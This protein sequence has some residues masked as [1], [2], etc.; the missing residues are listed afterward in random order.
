MALVAQ[1]ADLAASPGVLEQALNL[2]ET[3]SSLMTQIRYMLLKSQ[4]Y[5]WGTSEEDARE[6]TQNCLAR[7]WAKRLEFDSDKG[8]PG[9]WLHGFAIRIVKEHLQK[10]N[11]LPKQLPEDRELLENIESPSDKIS[12]IENRRGIIESLLPEFNNADQQLL[13]LF[14][15]EQRSQ[16]ELVEILSI[17]AG[18]LRTRLTRVRSKLRALCQASQQ[19]DAS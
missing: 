17:S 12:P 18:T 16:K 7:A 4:A 3:T 8:E 5:S 2:P 9:A 14:L 6:L 15:F 13:Q 1:Q 10:L 19:E 11:R